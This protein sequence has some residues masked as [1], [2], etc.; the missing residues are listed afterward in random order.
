MDM[1]I[2]NKCFTPLCR[3]KHPYYITQ[4]GHISCQT[5]L[6]QFEK[7]CP[8][9][10][11][12]GT[13]SLALEEPLI[14]KLTP[15]FHTSV[16]ET[17]EM[18]LK[19]YSFRNNQ[20]TISMQRF[21]EIDKKYDLLKSK[22]WQT[23]R[24]LKALAEKYMITKKTNEKLKKKLLFVEMANEETSRSRRIETPM[25]TDSGISSN[26]L[27]TGCSLASSMHFMNSAGITPPIRSPERKFFRTDGFR[28]PINR[29]LTTKSLASSNMLS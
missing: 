7:Q 4:C 5:C 11:R 13:I 3:G 9:C 1:L 29:K 18:L 15:F 21:Q 6:Q 8:Q 14:P 2:C 22:Y 27:R 12:V 28:I 23:H 19:V 10:Q 25:T 20:L 16:V 17:M 26:Q 24:D